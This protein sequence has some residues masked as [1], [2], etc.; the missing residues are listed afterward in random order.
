MF[1]CSG[2]HFAT[3]FWLTR[4]CFQRALGCIYLIAFLI[5][6]NQFIPLLGERG[7][8]PVGRFLRHVAFSPRAEFV[9]DQL[10]GSLHHR[11]DLVRHRV[12]DLRCCRLV[13]IVRTD[14]VDA[15]VGVALDD[16]PLARQ[17]RPNLLRLWLGNDAH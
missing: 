8:Q 16:L 1:R 2:M 13:G 12:V 15:H 7:L 11:S 6:A 4:L 9:L 10:L 5:A 14:R 3:E 17:R